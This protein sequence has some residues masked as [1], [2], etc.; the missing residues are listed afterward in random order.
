MPI[1]L[2][3]EIKD[4]ET[5]LPDPLSETATRAGGCRRRLR[6][7]ALFLLIVVSGLAFLG[8]KIR[9]KHKQIEDE[10]RALVEPELSALIDGD[11]DLFLGRQAPDA[12]RWRRAQ[13]QLF[14]RYHRQFGDSLWGETPPAVRY[15]G[16]VPRLQ[17]RED[18]I[19]SGYRLLLD[20]LVAPYGPH[21]V[22][23]L[24]DNVARTDDLDRW[25]HLSTGHGLDEIEP[26]WLLENYEG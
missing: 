7:L 19:W 24:L 25:L 13:E 15:T 11:H 5:P 18:Q 17:V 3:W 10:L 26:A 8:L 2:D 23:A 14:D 12:W 6:L 4:D 16:Q 1:Q 20:Y 22:P 9:Q 21:V